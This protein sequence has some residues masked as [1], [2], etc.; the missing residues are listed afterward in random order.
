MTM[1]RCSLARGETVAVVMAGSHVTVFTEKLHPAAFVLRAARAL[2]YVCVA[3][4]LDDL[5]QGFCRGLDRE[6]AGGA[7]Q[8]PVASPVALVEVEVDDRNLFGADVF[9]DVDLG[10]VEQGMDPDVCAF[11]E[12]GLELV[13]QLRRLLPEIPVAVLVAR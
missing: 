8:A 10:P 5:V 3:Q 12:R 2:G 9:P 4:L 1:F 13:P 11:G 7:A 6:R